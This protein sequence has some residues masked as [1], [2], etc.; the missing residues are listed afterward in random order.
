[1]VP[2]VQAVVEAGNEA[3]VEAGTQADTQAEIPVD[4]S[5]VNEKL[6]KYSSIQK[7]HVKQENIRNDGKLLFSKIILN[8]IKNHE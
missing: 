4:I 1:M 6:I 3:D 5:Q 8:I 2:D 7:I